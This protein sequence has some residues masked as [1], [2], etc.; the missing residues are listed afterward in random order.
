MRYGHFGNG[1]YGIQSLCQLAIRGMAL[2]EKAQMGNS[3]Y[4]KRTYGNSP[5]GKW[6]FWETPILGTTFIGNDSFIK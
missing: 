3:P 5:F 6:P 4:V 2:L 1:P